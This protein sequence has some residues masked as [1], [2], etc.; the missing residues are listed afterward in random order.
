MS[1]TVT[2]QKRTNPTRESDGVAPCDI[3]AD[4]KKIGMMRVNWPN[5]PIVSMA[6]EGIIS[7]IAF[8]GMKI[9]DIIGLLDTRETTI[10]DKRGLGI[11]LHAKTLY[12]M[13]SLVS[14]C[15]H[16]TRGCRDFPATAK[17][18]GE[19]KDVFEGVERRLRNGEQHY[20]DVVQTLDWAAEGLE[21]EEAR[22]KQELGDER[23]SYLDK[24]LGT[25]P[26]SIADKLTGM[27]NAL[28]AADKIFK[29]QHKEL[30]AELDR[31]SS[32]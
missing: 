12:D 25:T 11:M 20:D 29:G 1:I 14:D 22:V 9:D 4:G 30:L 18:Y 27:A 19:I 23:F 32:R 26:L 24:Q 2:Q 10:P 13:Q 31:G 17:L 5:D 28:A 7:R 8:R 3:F 15:D 6:D 21:K 16:A